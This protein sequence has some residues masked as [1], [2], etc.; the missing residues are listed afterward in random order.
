MQTS[1][2]APKTPP[3]IREVAGVRLATAQSGITYQRRDDLMLMCFDKGAAVAGVF[4]HSSTAAAPVAWCRQILNEK[5]KIKAILCNAGNANA[6]TGEE[7]DEAV[8][9]CAKAVAEAAGCAANQVIIAS[10]GVIGERLPHENITPHIAG[11]VKSA[12]AKNWHEA[13]KAIGTTDTFPKA[14]S[15]TAKIGDSAGTDS[16]ITI[17]GIAKGSGMI[18]PNMATMLGFIATDANLSPPILQKLLTQLNEVSFNA[19]TVDGDTSTND[20]LIL[21]ATAEAAH[22]P[23]TRAN[24]PALKDF[25]KKLLEVMQELA[26]LIIRDGEGARKLITIHVKG[27]ENDSEAKRI[28]LAIGNSLLV[29]TAIAGGDANWGRIIMAI[30]KAGANIIPQKLAIAIG[31]TNITQDGKRHQDYDEKT[32]TAYMQGDEI[33]IEVNLNIAKG[34]ATIWT[35]D[36][37]ERYIAINADYRS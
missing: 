28:G 1:P 31:G 18:A 29:K 12:D 14:I 34:Q 2:L 24:D 35:C 21:A 7:G 11:M 10:T 3:E 8:K 33:T 4:T 32:L 23:I 5:S 13:S 9:I 22:K 17:T 27:A 36:L 6:F 26:K 37:T 20:T 25:T 15:R 19:I 16:T 30:G